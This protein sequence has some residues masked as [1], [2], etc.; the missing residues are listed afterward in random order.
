MRRILASWFGM[1]FVPRLVWKGEGGAGTVAGMGAL[2][3]ALW[4]GQASV[5]WQLA[6]VIVIAGVGLWA[7]AP[8]TSEVGDPNW[9][10][11]DEAAGTVLAVTG[12][13]GPAVVVA[14]LVF[15]AADITKRLPLVA[16]A[17][18]LPGAVG[19]MAD[20]LVAGLYALAAGW[21]CQLLIQ[22][23]V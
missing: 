15:R 8:F 6:M 21:A 2:V 11:I 14:F 1:G 18:R 13:Q 10:T 5:L 4:A 19:V 16:K 20:D 17:E 23:V 9:V 7:V 3:L 12:L 22:Q